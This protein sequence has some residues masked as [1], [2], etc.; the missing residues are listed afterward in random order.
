MQQ[1]G[2]QDVGRAIIAYTGIRWRGERAC[3]LLLLDVGW[4][5]PPHSQAERVTKD[6]MGIFISKSFSATQAEKVLITRN[7]DTLPPSPWKASNSEGDAR[8]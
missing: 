3:P 1:K 4:R 7:R 8:F 2:D 6:S 5:G